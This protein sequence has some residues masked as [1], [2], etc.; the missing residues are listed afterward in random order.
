MLSRLWYLILAL[1]VGAALAGAFL[2]KSAASREAEF[3][4]DE[5]LR[6]DRIEAELWMRLDARLRLDALASIAVEP[7]VRQ[8]LR[9]S[10]GR[11]G[12]PAAATRRRL[13]QKLNALNAKLE[14]G[15]GDMVFAVDAEGEVV[16]TL[17]K[18]GT[19][20]ERLDKMPLVRDALRGFMRD[21]VWVYNGEVFRMAARPVFDG[22]RYVGAIVHGMSIGDDLARRLGSKLPNASVV[23]FFRD[24]LIGAHVGGAAAP[25]SA[26]LKS[27]LSQALTRT[28]DAGGSIEIGER[29]RA[30]A[31]PIRGEAAHAQVG[32]IIGRKGSTVGLGGLFANTFKEDV[33]SLPWLAIIG[34][35]LLLLV[36]GLFL[37]YLEHDKA[38]GILRKASESLA[39]N[40]LSSLPEGDLRRHY[41]KVAENFNVA[42]RAGVGFKEDRAERASV[43]LDHILSTTR[44]SADSGY[45]AF[46][47][48]AP[49]AKQVSLDSEPEHEHEPVTASPHMM[50]IKGAPGSNGSAAQPEHGVPT[51]P[52]QGTPTA[53]PNGQATARP[54]RSPS[55]RP[56]RAPSSW[57]ARAPSSR[58]PV[59]A[60]VRHNQE[61]FTPAPDDPPTR[62]NAILDEYDGFDH[63]EENTQIK[64]VPQELLEASAP[65]V[66]GEETHFREVFEQFVAMQKECGGPVNGLTF[67]KFVRKLHAA[68]EQVMKRH[69]AASVRFTVYV[70]EGRA[71][72]KASPVKQ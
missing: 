39:K 25:S 59:A 37:L 29:T 40:E 9:S 58:H 34:L 36:L 49:T 28:D 4:L 21:D 15:K 43:D 55:S 19:G 32:Y 7:E 45:F 18:N 42:L 14:E 54:Q 71:A 47:E 17:D 10:S 26:E 23:F 33:A 5:Q 61:H 24:R 63:P 3:Q 44:D 68:R 65:A 1:A 46:A 56:K 64:H 62:P 70:K 53:R 57:P 2:N 67:D 22:G 60:T 30:I 41:R 27:S 51:A 16:A 52:P 66:Q 38:V 8:T 72:L 6:R 11:F 69:D 12:T 35:P 50:P 31:S 13:S 20:S 48:E